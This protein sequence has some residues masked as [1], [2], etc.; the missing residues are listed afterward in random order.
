MWMAASN[1]SVLMSKRGNQMKQLM[2]MFGWSATNRSRRG[3]SQFDENVGAAATVIT[4]VPS[5]YAIARWVATSSCTSVRR[6]SSR[7]RRPASVSTTRC[8][9]RWNRRVPSCSS[10][11]RI[12]RLTA[13]CVTCSSIAARVKLPWRAALSNASSATVVGR[14]VLVM[15]NHHDETTT[16]RLATPNLSGEMAPQRRSGRGNMIIRRSACA[17][18]VASCTSCHSASLTF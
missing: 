16:N 17:I 11:C 12:W 4:F 3:A 5:A 18:L 10:S 14:G 13:P 2:L 6:T 1:C 15:I 9:T 8:R 7:Y